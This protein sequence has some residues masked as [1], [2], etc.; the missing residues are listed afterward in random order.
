MFSDVYTAVVDRLTIRGFEFLAAEHTAH[1][2][3]PCNARG[4]DGFFFES[5]ANQS[6]REFF[7]R[8]CRVCIDIVTQPAHWNH[9]HISC[10]FP[11]R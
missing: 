7:G 6:S 2:E 4:V 5:D 11:F 1:D 3:R 9:W 8:H 10:P